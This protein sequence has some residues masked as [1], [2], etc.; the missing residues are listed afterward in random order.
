MSENFNLH[1]AF[2]K[3]VEKLSD[4]GDSLIL[5]LPN[6]VLAILA[7]VAFWFAAK[8][9]SKFIRKVLLKKV[10]Q[11]SIKNIIE[12][13]VYIII[14]SIGFFVALGIL[15]LSKVLTSVL[16]SAGIIGLAIGL[17]LQGTLNNT[18]SG[19]ILSFLPRVRIGDWVDTNG[20]SG[21][22]VDINLRSIAILQNDNNYVLI[23]NSKIIDEPIKNYTLTKRSRIIVPCGVG[24]ESDLEFVRELVIKTLK[25]R[26]PQEEK[27]EVELFYTEFG[28]SS[29]N[30]IARFWIDAL[31]NRD[32][33]VARSEAILTIKKAFN[34]NNVNIPFPIRTLDFGKNKFRAEEITLVQKENSGDK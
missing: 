34:E 17:A 9:I 27:E 10:G 14:V 19:I 23:P 4:W 7:F 6:L 16:A 8:H 18:F 33:Q 26:F 28:S 31:D 5:K 20:F 13:T 24:Y 11:E 21:R 32:L 29:I 15:D 25:E 22:I 2:E 12:K 3:L 1:N 30:F